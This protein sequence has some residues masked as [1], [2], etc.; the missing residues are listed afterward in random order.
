MKS[1]TV[2]QAMT[3]VTTRAFMR[4]ILPIT[5]FVMG[6]FPSRGLYFL[7]H[8]SGGHYHAHQP[9]LKAP[10][11]P[12]PRLK[13]A[14]V[15]LPARLTRVPRTLKRNPVLATPALDAASALPGVAPQARA[16][17]PTPDSFRAQAPPSSPPPSRA[18]PA[19]A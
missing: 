16:V 15:P 9:V 17:R 11:S 8:P 4:R 10:S 18:P 3:R 13:A 7:L 1:Y 6:C 5:L 14:K 2:D 12:T 19:V